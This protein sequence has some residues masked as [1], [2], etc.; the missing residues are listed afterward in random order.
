VAAL[1]GSAASLTDLPVIG[2]PFA[3]GPLNGFRCAAR[4]PTVP[5][6]CRSPGSGIDN[7]KTRLCW[8]SHSHP[9]MRVGIGYDSHRFRGEGRKLI[10]GGVEIPHTA[11]AGGHSDADAVGARPDRRH[12]RRRGPGRH[13]Q[14]FLRRTP[15]GAD[16]DSIDLLK[17]AY[18]RVVEAGFSF[19]A[20][21]SRD[22]RAAQAGALPGDMPRENSPA[23][24]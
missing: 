5:G 8:R 15:A 4:S 12:S 16:A 13:R 14:M 17:K 1:P 24:W 3:G 18:L 20:P 21:T 19:V 7:A 23:H 10:L 9:D 2:V 6:A 11:R 22:H